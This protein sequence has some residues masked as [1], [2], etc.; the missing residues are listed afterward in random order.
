MD[1]ATLIYLIKLLFKPKD[2][3]S[4][5]SFRLMSLGMAGLVG[6]WGLNII[7]SD[8]FLEKYSDVIDRVSLNY[9]KYSDIAQIIS[10]FFLVAGFVLWC[11]C[12]YFSLRDLNKR[13]IAL[14]RAYGFENTDPQAAEKMLSFREKSKILHVDFKAFDSRNKNNNL[15]N[16]GFIRQVIRERIHHSGATAAYVA[17]L[18][19]VP[20]LY[21]I[22]S[23]M[24]DGH[25]TL[26][27]F[28]FD[29]DK[30]IFHP[31]DAPPTNA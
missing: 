13:D 3:L 22:G 31:L 2:Q 28:D 11:V 1:K 8:V 16:A 27:L 5:L 20:Y 9:Q 6:G 7:F 18:G 29:R 14:I 4:R 24:T 26:K 21:M 19:S 17:A 10:L 15:S 30:K 25:L 23:F 12:V